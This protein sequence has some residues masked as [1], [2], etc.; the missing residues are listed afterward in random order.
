MFYAVVFYVH[1]IK[2]YL[3]IQK[4]SINYGRDEN[5]KDTFD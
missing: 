4:V 1:S 5:T 2:K 3:T